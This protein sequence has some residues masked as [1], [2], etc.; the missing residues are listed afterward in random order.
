MKTYT[1]GCH[2]QKVRYEVDMEELT[3][4]MACNCSIC[5]KRGWLLTFVPASSFRLLSGA[6]EVTTYH[7][8]NKKIDHIFCKT[9]GV[10]AYGSGGDMVS[11]NVRCLDDVILEALKINHV[12]GKSF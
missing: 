4:A 7:F 10:A 12:D 3:K 6:D 11:I 1:G 2:C 8:N 5:S 9:C